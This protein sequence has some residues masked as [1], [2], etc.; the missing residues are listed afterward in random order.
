MPHALDIVRDGSWLTRERLAGYGTLLLIGY[1]AMLGWLVLGGDGIRD[2]LGRPIGTD[3]AN[4]WSSGQLVL[5][6]RPE[7][8]FDPAVQPKQTQFE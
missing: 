8:A 1:A 3:F 7:V 6:G 5:Q 4:I 2:A